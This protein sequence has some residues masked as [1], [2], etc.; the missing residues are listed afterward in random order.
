ME[1]AF[2]TNFNNV[3]IHTGN[4]AKLINAQAHTQGNNIHFA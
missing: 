4:Q 1:K 2:S 3:R